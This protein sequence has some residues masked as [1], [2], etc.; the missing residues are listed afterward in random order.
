[1]SSNQ[2][3]AAPIWAS[4]LGIIIIVM[5]VYLSASHGNQLMKYLV[6]DGIPSVEMTEYIYKCPED[7]LEEEGITLEMCKQK[8]A[9]VDTTLLSIPDWFRGFQ[10]PL[11]TLGTLIAFASIFAGVALLEYRPIAPL[12][13]TAVI[14][15]LLFIDI[16]GFIV[17]VSTGPL[18]RQLYLWDILLWCF[19][20]AILLAAITA[21]RH[22]SRLNKETKLHLIP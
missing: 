22:E 10:I 2:N 19:I 11:M 6:L 17:V 8:T 9:N 7:E 1:M 5:G 14:G 15:A 12:L 18:T 13:A 20:H 3:N 4:W 21:G 16:A